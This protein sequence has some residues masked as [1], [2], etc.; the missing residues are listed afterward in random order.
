MKKN[1]LSILTTLCVLVAFGFSSPKEKT[2]YTENPTETIIEGSD[3]DEG[4][5]DGYCEGWKDVKGQLALCPLTPLPPL[6][7][8][9]KDTYRGGYNMG[10]KAG[11]KAAKK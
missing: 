7:P 11:M 6:P 8:L 4:W 2:G 9:G 1:L 5:E 3:F 10:F